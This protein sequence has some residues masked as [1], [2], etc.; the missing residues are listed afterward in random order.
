MA[1][2]DKKFCSKDTMAKA[3]QKQRLGELTLKDCEDPEDF[4]LKIVLLKLE[5]NNFLSKEN[6][7]VTLIGVAGTKYA[8]TVHSEHKLIKSRGEEITFRALVEATG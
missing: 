3:Q 2:L 4:S 8:A 6:K 7:L 5:F 1:L